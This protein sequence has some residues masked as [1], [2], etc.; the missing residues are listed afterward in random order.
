MKPASCNQQHRPAVGRARARPF[1][2]PRLTGVIPPIALLLVLALLLWAG[3]QQ[4]STPGVVPA[5]A[6]ASEF[7]G[8]RA[9]EH[10]RVIAAESRSI[11][12]P[13]HVAARD[14]LVEQLRGLGLSPEVQ[15]TTV[16]VPG[17]A[18]AEG[19]VAATVH[20]V[21][22]RVPGTS[23]TGAL[24]LNAHFD[25]G[26]TGPGA[27][28]AG[29]G[30]VTVLETVRALQSGPALR[31]DLIVVFADAEEVGMLGAAAFNEQHPWANDV[32][33]ALNYEGAGGSGP[34]Y[35][36]ATTEDSWL[37]SEYLEVAPDPSASSLMAEIVDLYAAGRLD[38][39]LGEYTG[40]GSADQRYP[41]CRIA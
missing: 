38:C 26:S 17:E 8:E 28:D 13:G 9:M 39:D 18:G 40:R 21:V 22:V 15:T 30:V 37:V 34:A 12:S 11:G 27:M 33:V 6:P 24:A 23:S 1:E 31:N 35:L 2:I 32:R 20:N 4:L 41:P 36:Y 10:L 19:V 16:L 29:S 5:S 3:L 14:Y 7:S 25:S